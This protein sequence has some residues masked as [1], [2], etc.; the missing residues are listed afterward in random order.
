M[1][2]VLSR[3]VLALACLAVPAVA[4]AQ[5]APADTLK[6]G[7]ILPAFDAETVAGGQDKVD[8]KQPTVLLFFLSSC[9]HCHRQIPDWNRAFLRKKDSPRVVGVIMDREPPGFFSL[10]TVAFPVLRAPGGEFRRTF[11]VKSV[12]MTVRVGPG[13]VVED[14]AMGNIDPIR[15]G[16]LFRP[17]A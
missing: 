15:L 13:G 11:K 14:V 4:S 2:A 16:E 9:S 6:K 10:T 8:F 1:S 7:D 17:G 12:P 3:L 5:G